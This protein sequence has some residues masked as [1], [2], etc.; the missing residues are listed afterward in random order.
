[1]LLDTKIPAQVSWLPLGSVQP[2][3]LSGRLWILQPVKS[4]LLVVLLC[5]LLP[6]YHVRIKLSVLDGFTVPAAAWSL[7]RWQT[8]LLGTGA[9]LS[10]LRALPSSPMGGTLG[11]AKRLHDPPSN[12]SSAVTS[13]EHLTWISLS[14]GGS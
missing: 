6:L 12:P 4:V 1:M 13:A 10:P 7:R 2:E 5:W 11:V 3:I 14:C 9:S 8:L